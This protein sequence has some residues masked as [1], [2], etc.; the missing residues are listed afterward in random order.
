M[1]ELKPCPFCGGKARFINKYKGMRWVVCD[2]C[3]CE[4]DLFSTD[5]KAVEAWNRRVH[6]SND[7]TPQKDDFSKEGGQ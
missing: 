7:F 5:E 1:S 3:L 6:N 2:Y 4:T